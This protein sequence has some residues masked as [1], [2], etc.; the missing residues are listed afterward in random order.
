MVPE[1]D[2]TAVGTTARSISSSRSLYTAPPSPASR[3]TERDA[4]R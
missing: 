3:R 4:T 2:T 1:A